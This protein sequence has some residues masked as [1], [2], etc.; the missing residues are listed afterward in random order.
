METTQMFLSHLD[1]PHYSAAAKECKSSLLLAT[2]VGAIYQ[3]PAIAGTIDQL[4]PA[5]QRSSRPHPTTTGQ[6]R[7]LEDYINDDSIPADE[8][9]TAIDSTGEN[10]FIRSFC[11]GGGRS[12]FSRGGDRGRGGQRSYGNNSR[13]QYQNKTASFKGKC[14]G[15]DMQNHH[16]DSCHFLLKLRQA[17]NYLG[18]DPQAAF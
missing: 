12:P 18:I 14:N 5:Q 2:T 10:P 1:D 9:S 8:Y 16:A 11:R 7:I 6:I 4:Q 3:V 13:T 17:I 15:Y